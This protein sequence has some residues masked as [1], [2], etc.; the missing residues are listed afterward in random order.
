MSRPTGLA[1]VAFVIAVVAGCG[2]QSPNSG[3]TP[4]AG[5]AQ[6]GEKPADK[7]DMPR[8]IIYTSAVDVSV[9]D[10]DE[11]VAKARQF[12]AGI[13]GYVAKSEVSGTA[14][15]RRTATLTARVP[16]D[17]YDVT[18][19]EFGTLGVPTRSASDA[20]DVT[21]EFIDVQARLRNLKAEEQA[22]NKLL[23]TSAGKLEDVL[24]I[25]EHVVRVRSDIERVEG[26]LKYLTTM[27]DLATVV[28]TLR[29]EKEYIPSSAPSFAGRAGRAFHDS[30]DALV[31]FGE[32]VALAAVAV[33]P[34]L[35]V[36]LFVGGA[37]WVLRRV[38][39]R[40]RAVG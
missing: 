34:W 4:V 15:Y 38:S 6:D 21:E 17:K 20:Q 32:N 19:A 12:V 27:T 30:T 37:V 22:L 35:P 36:V 8:K 16:A 29:E 31:R 2:G 11:A 18:V 9:K 14:G 7:G 40:R 25:R 10:V 28:L 39:R 3:Q 24:K 33:V 13:K 5:A 23:E 1:A 26:R